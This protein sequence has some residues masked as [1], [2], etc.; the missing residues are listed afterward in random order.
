MR[1]VTFLRRGYS[2]SGGAEAYLKRLAEAV[3]GT[4]REVRLLGDAWPASEWPWG[5]C[6]RLRGGSP[7][8][9]AR[10]VSRFR[11]PEEILFSFERIPGCD[12]FRAG[13]GLHC[14]W[15][16]RRRAFE[17][18]WKS[19]LHP[20]NPK[21]RAV[22]DL[23]RRLFA[24]DS[25]TVVIANSGLVAAEIRQW[26]PAFPSGRLHV[27]PNGYDPPP[28]LPESGREKA[29][30]DFRT[31]HGVPPQA[32]VALFLGTGWERKGLRFAIEA[33]ARA[34]WRLIVAG[35]GPSRR[36]SAP[37][38]LHLGESKNLPA[39]FAACDVLLHPT[40]YDPFSN[41]CLEALAA[42]LPVITTTANG[43]AE[44]LEQDVTGSVV[45]RPDALGELEEALRFWKIQQPSASRTACIKAAMQYPMQKNRDQTIALLRTLDEHGI[46]G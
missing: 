25:K 21:H 10:E 8:V 34:G 22:L 31:A 37:H 43:A 24:H 12:I 5:Q 13:D 16:D 35:R 23:E 39:L 38:V 45:S 15:I 1:P 28:D 9:F 3:A 11:R 40:W 6:I 32:P 41:A 2:A 20:L 42:G 14:A 46:L 17:P 26:F 30:M 18:F 27:I 33:T 4:G 36:H 19:A 29:R 44:I 7:G